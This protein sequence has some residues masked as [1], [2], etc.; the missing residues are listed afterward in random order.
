MASYIIRGIDVE[1]W[2]RVKDRLKQAPRFYVSPK[3]LIES[4]LR[5]WLREQEK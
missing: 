1:L 4:L 2:Q 5:A 3:D